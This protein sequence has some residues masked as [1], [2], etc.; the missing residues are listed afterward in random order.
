M[1]RVTWCFWRRDDKR[2]PHNNAAVRKHSML[3][4]CRASVED[5]VNIETALGGCHMFALSI[6][7]TQRRRRLI[8]IGLAM[9][10]KD[11][12][13]NFIYITLHATPA[14]V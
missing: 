4:Q 11:V 9:G 1:Y 10:I 12:L 13:F 8:G 5:W 6:Q 7:Q 3:F 2:H 14:R